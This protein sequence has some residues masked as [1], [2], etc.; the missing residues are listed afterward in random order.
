[1]SPSLRIGNAERDQAMNR[2]RSAFAEGRLD[3]A[4][5]D[6]RTQRALDARTQAELDVLLADLPAAA[7]LTDPGMSL[8]TMVSRLVS[9]CL[10]CCRP[11]R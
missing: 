10:C 1:M 7:E 8:L 2:L 9:R 5:L 4:D 6:S 3:E 11:R